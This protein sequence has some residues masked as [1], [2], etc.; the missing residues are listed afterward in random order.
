ME[1]HILVSSQQETQTLHR[2]RQQTLKYD[3]IYFSPA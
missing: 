1:N 2:R 3:T